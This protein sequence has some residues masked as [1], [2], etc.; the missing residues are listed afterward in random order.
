MS[1]MRMDGVEEDDLRHLGV[2]EVGTVNQD[3]R[4]FPEGD[5][6]QPGVEDEAGIVIPF[7]KI[8]SVEHD[9]GIRVVH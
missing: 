8:Q 6:L 7:K 1:I 3:G 2:R 9:Q 4:L 5:I